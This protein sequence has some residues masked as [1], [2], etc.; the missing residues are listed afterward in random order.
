VL[1]S[2]SSDHLAAVLQAENKITG[3]NDGPIVLASFTAGSNGNLTTSNTPGKMA[4][5]EVNG[6]Y[7]M[8]IS[9]SGKL[10]AVAGGGPNHPPGGNGF[11]IFHFNGASPITHY[12]G[13]LQDKYLI[14]QFGWDKDNHLYVLGGGY[15][16]VYTVTPTSIK[17]ASGSPYSIPESS[18]LIV[19]DSK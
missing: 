6:I 13:L 5:S 15:L 16:F 12:S 10:L 8:S 9:P 19:L 14:S 18:S 17:E 3:D 11:Q 4:A 1:A 7:V 2:D